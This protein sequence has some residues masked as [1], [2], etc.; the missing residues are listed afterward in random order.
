MSYKVTVSNKYSNGETLKLAFDTNS[1]LLHE[2][3]RDAKQEVFIS[4]LNSGANPQERPIKSNITYKPL[5]GVP[6]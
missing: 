6:S 5:Q 1:A 4:R 3:S 2:A